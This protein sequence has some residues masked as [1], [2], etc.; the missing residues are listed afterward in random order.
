GEFY[1]SYKELQSYVFREN[2]CEHQYAAKPEQRESPRGRV[3]VVNVVN[4]AGRTGMLIFASLPGAA[5]SGG[6]G[7]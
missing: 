3:N 4:I 7:C 2:G 1:E 6:R 5:G